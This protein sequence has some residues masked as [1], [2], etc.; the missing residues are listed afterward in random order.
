MPKIETAGAFGSAERPNSRERQ[1]AASPT[2][3]EVRAYRNLEGDMKAMLENGQFVEVIRLSRPDLWSNMSLKL[4]LADD[5]VAEEA[6]AKIDDPT[7]VNDIRQQIE[8]GRVDTELVQILEQVFLDYGPDIYMLR[9]EIGPE[10]A[11]EDEGMD[12]ARFGHRVHFDNATTFVIEK[13]RGADMQDKLR[14]VAGSDVASPG[15]SFDIEPWNHLG[16]DAGFTAKYRYRNPSGKEVTAKLYFLYAREKAAPSG[17][18][19]DDQ[20][21]VPAGSAANDDQEMSL[22]A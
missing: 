21:S 2:D 15:T 9:K 3:P 12:E 16:P 7:A 20:E 4:D 5:R 19:N 14:S 13:S 6:E 8:Q 17:A 22:T 1:P 10:G 18:I 11:V